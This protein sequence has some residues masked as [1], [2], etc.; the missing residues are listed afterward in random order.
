MGATLASSSTFPTI[1]GMSAPPPL[2]LMWPKATP[3]FCLHI[4]LTVF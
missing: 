1:R 2:G 4:H 3:R